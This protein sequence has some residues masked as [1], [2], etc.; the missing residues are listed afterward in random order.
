MN[1]GSPL[2][3]LDRKHINLRDCRLHKLYVTVEFSSLKSLL[4]VVFYPLL[5][6]NKMS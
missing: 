6:V 4:H 3:S 2:I 5:I 1:L